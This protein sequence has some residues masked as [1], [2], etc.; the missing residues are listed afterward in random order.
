M[1]SRKHNKNDAQRKLWVGLIP[2]L[3][4]VLGVLKLALADR[5]Y[6]TF[7][8]GVDQSETIDTLTDRLLFLPG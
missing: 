2:A 5:K 7:T 4:C 6:G 3:I 8:G 1:T